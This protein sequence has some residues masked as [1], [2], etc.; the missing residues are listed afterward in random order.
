VNLQG[1]SLG[2]LLSAAPSHPAFQHGLRLAGQAVERGVD[3]YLYCLDDA[4]LGLQNGYL[5]SLRLRGLRLF[6][7]ALGARRRNLP[8]SDDAIFAGLGTLAE[9]AA[10]TDRFLSFNA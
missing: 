9:I 5:Q 4:V 3:V 1:K 2:I 6:A 10:R 8:F 7:C